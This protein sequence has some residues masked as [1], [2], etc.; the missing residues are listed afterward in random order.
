MVPDAE[1]VERVR[2]G[3]VQAY[4]ALVDRYERAVFAAV[5]PLLGNQQAAED[6]A[7][8]VF[9]QGYLRLGTLRDGRKFGAWL[10]SA[11]CGLPLPVASLPR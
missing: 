4:G 6:T 1:V 11:S 2:C 7:Q 5:L 3:D 9:V 8:D 10:I